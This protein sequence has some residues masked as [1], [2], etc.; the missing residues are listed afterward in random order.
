MSK[1]FYALDKVVVVVVAEE[2]KDGMTI[3]ELRGALNKGTSELVSIK[4]Y[5]SKTTRVPWSALGQESRKFSAQHL[6]G[7]VRFNID[8]NNVDGDGKIPAV[9]KALVKHGYEDRTGT[10][11]LP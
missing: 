11:F 10:I 1:L 2:I 6:L 5:L 8:F 4:G 9:R 7:Y 3:D